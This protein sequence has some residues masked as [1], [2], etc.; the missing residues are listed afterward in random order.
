VRKSAKKISTAYDERCFLR[1]IENNRK[2]GATKLAAEIENR[3]H[4]KVN[5]ET[6]RRVLRKNDFHGRGAKKV[7]Y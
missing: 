6:V 2:L 5:F 4:K 3:L 7:L 1:K